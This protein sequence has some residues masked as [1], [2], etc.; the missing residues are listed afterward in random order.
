MKTAPYVFAFTALSVITLTFVLVGTGALHPFYAR[1]ITGL[2][3]A[4]SVF[5]A[6]LPLHKGK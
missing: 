3:V 2:V 5:L 4:L 6:L 1:A